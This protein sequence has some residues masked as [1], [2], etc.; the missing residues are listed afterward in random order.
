MSTRDV[1]REA[2]SEA[3]DMAEDMIST[4]GT[5]QV[6]WGR[7]KLERYC[8]YCLTLVTREP[9]KRT[10]TVFDGGWP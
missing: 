2:S 3:D 5:F 10:N 6:V 8:G 1:F 7:L 9:V 4:L